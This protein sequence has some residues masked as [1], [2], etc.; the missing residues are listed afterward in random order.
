MESSD[1]TY[2]PAASVILPHYFTGAACFIVSTILIALSANDFTGHYFQ[3][4]LLGITHLLVLGWATM[5]IF[6]ALYQILPVIL[7]VKLYSESLARISYLLLLAGTS[8]IGYSFWKFNV[9]LTLQSGAIIVLASVSVFL[10]NV[11]QTIR[12]SKDPKTDSEFI[13]TSAVWL[14]LTVCAGTVLAFNLT[15][16]FLSRD[17]LEYLTMHAHMGFVGWFLLLI[18]GVGSRLF[19]MFLVSNVKDQR[20]LTYA[21]YL[22]NIG[23]I[24]F[25][26]EI[27]VMNSKL[28]HLGSAALI[29]TGLLSFLVFMKDVYVNRIKKKPD[30]PLKQG[31]LAFILLLLPL[32]SAGMLSL[33][34]SAAVASTSITL[35]YGVSIILGFIST[36]ILGK[37]YKTLPFILILQL[38]RKHK[39]KGQLSLK[40][41][42]LFSS[43][44]AT[45]QFIIYLSSLALFI[46][47][48]LIRQTTLISAGAI[49][50]IITAVIY[51]Y[52]LLQM[53]VRYTRK[54]GN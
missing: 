32:V 11:Y 13:L 18:I 45:A 23:L 17:H 15:L 5:I 53:L 35:V 22:I 26:L 3:P 28:L 27:L 38:S 14:W 25:C 29:L 1:M 19:P 42:D 51:N 4:H 46:T 31:L 9:G 44:M 48:I 2:T 40:Q 12:S 8:L 50:L 7:E 54:H 30:V 34:D 47:G 49:L 36:L 37:T 10:V 33:G 16:G 52:T 24:L 41:Q 6:G 39:G 43:R 20:K 21:Y